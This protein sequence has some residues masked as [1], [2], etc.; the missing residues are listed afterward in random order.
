M[1]LSL[2]AMVTHA[3]DLIQLHQALAALATGIGHPPSP[4]PHWHMI[5]RLSI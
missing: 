4:H 2:E 3:H 1:M 5:A